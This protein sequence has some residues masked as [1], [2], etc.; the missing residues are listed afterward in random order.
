MRAMPGF[1]VARLAQ[2]S[3]QLVGFRVINLWGGFTDST[4]EGRCV[5]LTHTEATI[6]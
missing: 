6:T 1:L 4:V 5:E 2:R 3:P